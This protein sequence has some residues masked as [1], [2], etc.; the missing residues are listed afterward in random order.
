MSERVY[1]LGRGP[2]HHKRV[3]LG[4]SLAARF[5]KISAKRRGA[6]TGD[7][8]AIGVR[9]ISPPPLGMERKDRRE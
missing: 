5:A 2:W 9:G 7:G 8:M 4:V 6:A 1:R 3:G